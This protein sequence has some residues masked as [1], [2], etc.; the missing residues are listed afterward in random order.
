MSSVIHVKVGMAFDASL[1]D[2]RSR[3]AGVAGRMQASR[4]ARSVIIPPRPKGG[5]AMLTQEQI[6][7]LT[8]LMDER[9]EREE[10]EILAATQRTREL[11]DEGR[12]SD[13]GDAALT[14]T[15]LAVDEAMIEQDAGDMRDID[16]ARE[17]VAT[18][19]YGACTECGEAI[20]YGRLLVYPTAK[21]CIRCQR[22]YERGSALG[23][24]HMP[25][26]TRPASGVG[27]GAASTTV[28]TSGKTAP[29]V[30]RRRRR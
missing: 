21:R 24:I 26:G 17:R 20:A 6:G 9:R 11:L 22:M 10:R 28:G 13:P 18:G 30:W 2:R 8:R 27:H 5:M 29:S 7:Y 15:A 14:G 12:A 23:R 1:G 16:A 19:I 4:P 3:N 25:P